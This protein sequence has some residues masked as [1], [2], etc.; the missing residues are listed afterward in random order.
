MSQL[1]HQGR[2]PSSQHLRCAQCLYEGDVPRNSSCLSAT[3]HAECAAPALVV[4][5]VAECAP[6][7][8]VTVAYAPT[9]SCIASPPAVYTARGGGLPSPQLSSHQLLLHTQGQRASALGVFAAP[10]PSASSGVRSTSSCVVPCRGTALRASGCN[11]RPPSVSLRLRCA[12]T[13]SCH[14]RRTRAS[15]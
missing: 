6:A 8:A 3:A 12:R 15:G 11:R 13:G 7:A 5:Q 10:V 9:V 14:D 2:S 1:Q 4:E